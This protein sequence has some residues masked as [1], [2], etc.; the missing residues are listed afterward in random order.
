MGSVNHR[1]IC[2]GP[3][4]KNSSYAGYQ[5]IYCMRMKLFNIFEKLLNTTV[6]SGEVE[7]EEKYLLNSYKGEKIVG[8]KPR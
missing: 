3:Y 8:V 6:V 1:Y 5:Y 4:R 2:I 7:F